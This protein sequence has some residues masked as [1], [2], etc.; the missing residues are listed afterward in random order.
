VFIHKRISLI[1]SLI[2]PNEIKV[3]EFLI[4]VRPKRVALLILREWLRKFY[5]RSAL[6]KFFNNAKVPS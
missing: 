5:G 4:R 1:K 2:K 6:T 3:R